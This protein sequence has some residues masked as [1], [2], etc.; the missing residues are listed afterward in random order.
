MSALIHVMES[1]FT[2]GNVLYLLQG[3]FT[4]L[5]VAVISICLSIIFGTVFALL[6]TYGNRMFRTVSSIYIEIF[7]NTPH[8]LW[9]F[10]IRFLI[11]IPEPFDAPVYSGILSFTLFTT[12]GMAEIIRGGLNSIPSGQFEGAYSQGFNFPQTLR[13][14][15]LPQCYRAIIPAML[16]QV[17]TV[18]K[19]TSFLAQVA[20][21]EFFNNSKW[22]MSAQADSSVDQTLR[23]FVIFGFVALVYFIINFVLSYIVRSQK[24]NRLE[25]RY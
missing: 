13:L 20:I 22:I 18:I 11:R 4:T 7:R 12:A 10:A 3:L 25:I 6:R 24:K 19:D 21:Q 14:I 8:L 16:S 9:V 2:R 1:V 15:I 17:I 5:F 23:V